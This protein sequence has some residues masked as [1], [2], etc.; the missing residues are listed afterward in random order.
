MNNLQKRFF[1]KSPTL[2]LCKVG[3]FLENRKIL[4][5]CLSKHLKEPPCQFSSRS[6]DPCQRLVIF[7]KKSPINCGYPCQLKGRFSSHVAIFLSDQWL[8][9][10]CCAKSQSFAK[11]FKLKFIIKS[12]QFDSKCLELSNLGVSIVQD[13]PVCYAMQIINVRVK[14]LR[15]RYVLCT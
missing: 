9:K 2:S 10:Y 12:M 13:K 5:N 3:N 4:Q 8:I 11:I 15:R 6:E 7:K 1:Q 14:E